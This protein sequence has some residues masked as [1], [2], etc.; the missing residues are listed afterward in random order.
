MEGAVRG[1]SYRSPNPRPA[2]RR[3]SSNRHR[4]GGR[5]Q[6]PLTLW[7]V[8]Q[9]LDNLLPEFFVTRFAEISTDKPAAL[10][11]VPIDEDGRGQRRDAVEAHPRLIGIED[12]RIGDRQRL[13]E[14]GRITLVVQHGDPQHDQPLITELLPDAFEDRHLL[15]ARGAPGR[16]EVQH[17]RFSPE[18]RERHDPAIKGA[19]AEVRSG[20]E[21]L[22]RPLGLRTARNLRPWDREQDARG[23]C[24]PYDEGNGEGQEQTGA[25]HGIAPYYSRRK[26]TRGRMADRPRPAVR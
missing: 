17:H 2:S 21:W 5:A 25:V 19:Q 22:G 24:G 20:D 11:L 15:P 18:V 3:S 10:T 13:E 1:A 23:E 4:D 9:E 8:V 12:V 14:R 26:Y 7:G 16:P 6:H